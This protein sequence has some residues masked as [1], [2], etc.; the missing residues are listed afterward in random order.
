MLQFWQSWKHSANFCHSFWAKWADQQTDSTAE[1]CLK[2]NK[3][4]F[5]LVRPVRV[6]MLWLLQ[7]K[8]PQGQVRARRGFSRAWPAQS[9]GL[10]LLYH[11]Q[12]LSSS[13]LLYFWVFC[14]NCASFA[15]FWGMLC[16]AQ[17]ISAS[18]PTAVLFVA[19]LWLWFD[20][21]IWHFLLNFLLANLK[22]HTP[23]LPLFSTASPA[24][25]DIQRA[26]WNI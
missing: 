5:C 24:S 7:R 10:Y 22:T 1:L 14:V 21:L 12:N 18:L 17:H 9:A 25:L 26:V 3:M 20:H 13:C 8:W 6:R 2:T 11:S 4:K 16:L 15:A 23:H 19:L